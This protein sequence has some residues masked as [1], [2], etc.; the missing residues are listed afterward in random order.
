LLPANPSSRV[1]A[2]ASTLL[3]LTFIPGLATPVRAQPAEQNTPAHASDQAPDG[4][5]DDIA[6]TASSLDRVIVTGTRASTRTVQQSAAPIDVID[7]AALN[8]TGKANLLEALQNLLP[9]FNLPAS[10]QPDLGSIVRG[11]QLRNLDPGYTLVL[12]NGKRRHTTAVTQD[13]GFSGSVWVDLG[14]IPVSS[15]ARVEVLRDGAAALYGS[16]AIAG[17]INLILK[18]DAQGGEGVLEHGLSYAGDGG[19]TK[20]RGN[21]G[22]PLGE[23]GFVN[24]SAEHT[25]QRLAVRSPPLREDYLLYPAIDT[26]SGQPVALAPGNRLPAGASPDPREATRPRQPWINQGVPEYRTRALAVN[27]GLPL[28]DTLELYGWGTLAQRDAASPQ[29]LRPAN[30]VFVNNPGLLDVYP[31]GFTPWER[32]DESDHDIVIGV[33]GDWAGWEWDISTGHGKDK[34]DVAVTQSANYSLTYPGGTTDF[35]AGSHLYWQRAA[36][37]DLRRAFDTHVL[38]GPLELAV[39]AEHLAQRFQLKAGEPDAWFGRG[40]N[41]VSGYLPEDALRTRRHSEAVYASAAA[42]VTAAWFVDLAGRYEHHSDFGSVST[43]RLST[44]YDITPQFGLRA[45]ISSG[46][47]APALVTQSFSGTFDSI[48]VINR[49]APAGTPEALALGGVAL[50]PETSDNL[51]LGFSWSPAPQ[52]QIALDLYQIEVR[53]RIA[54]SPQVGYDKSDPAKPVDAAARPLTPA[55]VAIIDDLIAGAG[56]VPNADIF[57]VRYFNNAG[58]TRSR[59]ADLT[60]EAT[61]DA[62]QWGR[63]RWTLAANYNKTTL[64]RVSELPG[65]LQQLPHIDLLS[66]ETQ[67]ELTERAPRRKEILGLNW[68]RDGWHAG[69]RLR[70]LGKLRRSE[71]GLQYDIPDAWLTDLTLGHDFRNGVGIEIGADNLL[72]RYPRR[73]PAQYRPNWLSQ[74]QYVYD[75]TGPLGLLGGY[76]YLRVRYQ[77]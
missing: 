5:A 19:V 24:I 42:E 25:R 28:G 44:R 33:K 43:G 12:V 75:N 16:D 2:V 58:D 45:T 10:I 7:A 67:L 18:S 77:F 35:Y 14:L 57:Y 48:G 39:G 38:A 50:E 3:A 32:T 51:S 62:G 17:V 37:V 9:S 66:A 40:S 15:I 53:G 73:L 74:Y 27:L 56:L 64:L 47:H 13:D 26:A 49:L 4:A 76:W 36:N 6:R 70:H 30:T 72:D 20:A 31:D 54:L 61:T 52:V 71:N 23:R 29:N 59:G 8:A 63:L 22:V 55:Q 65:Q 60:I 41:A 1:P 46:F 34:M 21:F 69:L 68:N 11:A